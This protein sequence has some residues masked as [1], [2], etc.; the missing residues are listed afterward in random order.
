[1]PIAIYIQQGHKPDYWYEEVLPDGRRKSVL[2]EQALDIQRKYTH[3]ASIVSNCS[4]HISVL[5]R[6]NIATRSH[7]ASKKL[8]LKGPDKFT[9]LREELPEDAIVVVR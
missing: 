4:P 3:R 7:T 8:G 5:P 2:G 9:A 6:S 1:M